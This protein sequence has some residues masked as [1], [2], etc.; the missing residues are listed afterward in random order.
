MGFEGRRLPPALLNICMPV[1]LLGIVHTGGA[2]ARTSE[3]ETLQ[4]CRY[5]QGRIEFYTDRRRLGGK[6]AQMERWR[7]SRRRFEREFRERRCHRYGRRLQG[8]R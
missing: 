1:L 7:K 4:R 6:G 2:A 3:H 5:L 8:D